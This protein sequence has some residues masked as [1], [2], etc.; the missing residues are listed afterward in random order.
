MICYGSEIGHKSNSDVK[1]EFSRSLDPR[2]PI[3]Y[4]TCFRRR[5]VRRFYPVVNDTIP[6]TTT[7]WRLYGMSVSYTHLRAHETDQYR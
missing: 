4:S 1:G 2:D 7:D 5:E 3:F 6:D